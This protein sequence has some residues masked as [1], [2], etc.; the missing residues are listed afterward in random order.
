MAR[1]NPEP[2]FFIYAGLIPTVICPFGIENPQ[3]LNAERSLPWD[4]LIDESQ[5]PITEK[6]GIPGE[7]ETSIRE[8]VVSVPEAKQE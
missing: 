5:S 3:D 1:S 8:T 6:D 4:S 2:A 7:M